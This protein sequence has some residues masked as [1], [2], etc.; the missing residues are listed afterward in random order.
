MAQIHAWVHLAAN[1]ALGDTRGCDMANVAVEIAEDQHPARHV[2]QEFKKA[3]RDR[4][5]QLCSDAGIEKA[6]QLADTLSLLIEGARVN[7]QS[8]GVDGPGGR[9]ISIAEAVIAA[10]AGTSQVGK[11]TGSMLRKKQIA[12]ASEA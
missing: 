7:T 6:D 10:F 11:V 2:I 1:Y 9:F 3:Q 12:I 8:V 4:L 5:A